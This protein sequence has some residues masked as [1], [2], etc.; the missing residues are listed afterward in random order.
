MSLIITADLHLSSNPRDRYRHAWVEQFIQLIEK[1]KPDA[2]IILGDLADEKDRH[3]GVLV[4]EIVS[5]LYRLAQTAP[6]IC[7]QGNHD[8]TVDPD[9]GFWPFLSHIPNV[10]WILR[11]MSFS[12]FGYDLAFLPH[13]RD[14]KRDWSAKWLAQGYDWIFCHNTFKGARTEHDRVLDGIPLSVF[15]Q[16]EANVISGDIHRPQPLGVVTYC[17]APYTIDFGDDYR[18]RILAIKGDKLTSIPCPGPQKRLVTI[19]GPEELSLQKHVAEGDLVKVRVNLNMREREHWPEIQK[20]IYLWA[21]KRG[22]SIHGIQPVFQFKREARARE[23]VRS[24][25]SDADTLRK[26]AVALG[27]SDGILSKGLELVND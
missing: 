22:C 6:V 27:L 5:Y 16:S 25:R 18:P 14:Y 20:A 13:T 7:L 2:V 9:N 19:R 10:T 8:Y 21:D 26:Y 1:R 15:K 17:G 3:A 23:V 12:R 4:N 11:P 24:K